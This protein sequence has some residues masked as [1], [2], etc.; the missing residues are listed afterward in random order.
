MNTRIRYA[1]I[2]PG[3][4]KSRRLFLTNTG[5]EVVV[6]LDLT[7]KRYQVLDS[8]TGGVVAEGGNTRNKSVLKI[9]AKKGLTSLGVQFDEEQ[10]NRANTSSSEALSASGR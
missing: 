2:A 5:Q 9:Q 8:V 4:L 6:Q 3:V 10:R 1:E 7:Q